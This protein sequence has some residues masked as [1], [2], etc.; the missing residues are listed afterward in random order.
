MTVK[1]VKFIRMNNFMKIM[2][3]GSTKAGSLLGS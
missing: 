2:K 1:K 3:P